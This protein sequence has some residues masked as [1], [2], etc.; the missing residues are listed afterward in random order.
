MP[1]IK[2]YT[3]L[4]H[5]DNYL[6]LT[7]HRRAVLH[8]LW[9]EYATSRRELPDNTLM[10]SR[11]LALKVTRRDLEALNHAG[12]IR[13]HAS[14]VAGKH[15]SVEREALAL[16]VVDFQ[17][18]VVH[19]AAPEKSRANT[20]IGRLPDDLVEQITGLNGSDGSTPA[21]IATF[22]RRGLPEAA[23]RNALEITHEASERLHGNEISYFVGTLR[24]LEQNGQY[25]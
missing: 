11:R 24:Q 5:D 22:V 25:R 12:F 14:K 8:G 17:A 15:A 20:K 6:T 21:V 2:V 1:W 7:G 10:I 18:A 9:L 23:F 16:D 19:Y 4:L 3:R 13:I